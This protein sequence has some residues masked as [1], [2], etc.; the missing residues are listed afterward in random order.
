MMA[1]A[2]DMKKKLNNKIK[3]ARKLHLDGQFVQA[4]KGYAKLLRKHSSNSTILSLMGVCLLQQNKYKESIGYLTR[5][6]NAGDTNPDTPYNLGIAHYNLKHF[7]EAVEA[8]KKAVTLKEDHDAAHYMMGR[9]CIK[10]GPDH[11]LEALEC[12]L[13]DIEINDRL[14]SYI[15]S[16]EI[17]LGEKR[18]TKAGEYARIVLE[19]SPTNEIGMFVLAKSI[20]LKDFKKSKFDPIF[21]EPAMKL[22]NLILQ[23]NPDSWRGHMVLAEALIMVGED[24]LALHHLEIIHKK[25]PDN[26]L[27]KSNMS[28]TLLKLGRLSEGWQQIDGRKDEAKLYGLDCDA[29]VKCNAPEWEGQI[30]SGKHLV[31]AAEQGIGDQLLHCQLLKELIENGMK[32]SVTCTEK[33]MPLLKRSLPQVDFYGKKDSLDSSILDTADYKTE[34]LQMC[35]LLRKDIS[36][37]TKPYYYLKPDVTL[38]EHFKEKYKMFGNKL[39]VGISWRSASR[40]SGTLKSTQLNEW[41]NILKVPNVQFI[42]IQ[43]KIDQEEIDQVRKAFDVDIFVDDFDPFQDIEKAVAQI[44]ALDMVISVSNAA[45]H[46]SGQLQIPTWV[47]ISNRPLWHWFREGSDSV[48]YESVKLY[49]QPQLQGWK[50]VLDQIATDLKAITQ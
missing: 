32:V 47:I 11:N 42:N 25:D 2:P 35:S 43:Y 15:I 5:A 27:Y 28:V 30:E 37:F 29:I 18:L 16:S 26:P 22:G 13:K 36:D 14:D 34:L 49:R 3:A 8:F 10:W 45:V 23:L 7:Q 1:V 50:P 9:S 48:W 6:M 17:F 4:E 46:M 33:I 21:V 12:F 39:K 44:S 40:S 19:R 41:E 38:S 31:V 24:E 20:L